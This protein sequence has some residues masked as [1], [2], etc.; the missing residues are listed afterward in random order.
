M[1]LQLEKIKRAHIL[2]VC[3]CTCK[4]Y[5]LMATFYGQT[6]TQKSLSRESESPLIS[7]PPV[8]P[9]VWS[10][11]INDCV[12]ERE[13][14]REQTAFNNAWHEIKQIWLSYPPLLNGG[15]KRQLILSWKPC[16]LIYILPWLSDDTNHVGTR[17]KERIEE[18]TAGVVHD[19]DCIVT[20]QR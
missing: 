6:H 18:S 3:A 12:R 20:F 8:S 19:T 5:I 4:L 15:G 16:S 1:L 10:P 13:R 2:R 17:D 14:E 11:W 7:P 9:P